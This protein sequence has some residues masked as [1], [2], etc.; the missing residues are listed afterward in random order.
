ME[1]IVAATAIGLFIGAL[2]FGIFCLIDKMKAPL[3]QGPI[4]KHIGVTGRPKE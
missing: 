1:W 4:D 3:G 2:G